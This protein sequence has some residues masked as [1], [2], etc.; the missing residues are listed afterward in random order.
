M[1]NT[2]IVI[3]G[4]AGALLLLG[5]VGYS[6][7][8]RVKRIGRDGMRMGDLISKL[9]ESLEDEDAW[10]FRPEKNAA[11]REESGKDS[12]EDATKEK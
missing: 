5:G 4:L 12:A 1:S 6:A 8:S 7:Y 10:R 9:E 3:L 2:L 11:K